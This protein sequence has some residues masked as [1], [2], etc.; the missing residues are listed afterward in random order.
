MN[1]RT[2]QLPD[3]ISSDSHINA[4][5][6]IDDEAQAFFDKHTLLEGLSLPL[7]RCSC[8][9]KSNTN[10]MRII[11]MCRNNNLFIM[12]G[13]LF[14]DQNIG[15]YTFRNKSVID[16]A[17]ASAECFEHIADFEITET[18]TLFSDGHSAIHFSIKIPEVTVDAERQQTKQMK[19]IWKSELRDVFVNNIN[20]NDITLLTDYLGNATQPN[21]AIEHV[22]NELSQIF[23]NASKQSSPES[24]T[25]P[26]N[27]NETSTKN[28]PWFGPKCQKAR[29]NYHEAKQTLSSQPSADNRLRLK[30]A[31]KHYKRTMDIFIK[32]HQNKT[33]VKLRNMNTKKL[34]NSKEYWKYLNSFKPKKKNECSPTLEEFYEHF[35]NINHNSIK[36]DNPLT[37][38]DLS[39][40]NEYLNS[41]ITTE[42]ILTCIKRLKNGKSPSYQDNILNEHIKETKDTVLP[43]YCKLFNKILDSG[44]LPQIWL[45]GSIIPIYKNKGER[46]DTS[47]Y[48]PITILSCLGKLFTAVLNQRLTT[49]LDMND[50]LDENQ[51]G[52]RHGYACSDHIFTLHALIEILKKQKKK[53]Y[54]AFIDFSQAFDKVWRNGLWYKLMQNSINGKFFRLINNMYNNIK[55]CV[56]LN[57]SFC[58][59]FM[60]EIGVRQGENLSPVLFSLFLNDLQTYLH[61]KGAVGVE[62]D[63]PLDLSLWLKLQSE[64]HSAFSVREK[65]LGRTWCR[66]IHRFDVK[67]RRKRFFFG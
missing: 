21:E 27:P 56:A 7:E 40:S 38:Y 62:L 47:N 8:D 43:L 41:Q 61:M 30:H 55:S 67:L 29:K 3:F 65:C 44:H 35:K 17:M 46:S 33:Q 5:L 20:P 10:G 16:Y 2:A 4:M 32:K 63:H 28:K 25:R 34:K 19:P 57:N 13:R 51:A 22:T 12:N 9:K 11:E 42:E 36:E 66:N 26:R 23:S 31:S 24:N 45:E 58:P 53:V 1:G 50:I 49:F 60:S 54:C 52:F 15:T 48:R 37:D 64:H 18:D 39:E 59:T 14:K 6:N